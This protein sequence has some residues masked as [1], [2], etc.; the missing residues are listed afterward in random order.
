MQ[1]VCVL[2]HHYFVPNSSYIQNRNKVAKLVF[3]NWEVP[4]GIS[5]VRLLI[6]RSFTVILSP[7]MQMLEK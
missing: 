5:I 3:L 6:M 4:V 2:F 1:F 7:S